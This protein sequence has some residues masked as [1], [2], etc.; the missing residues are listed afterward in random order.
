MP[1]RRQRRGYLD[2]KPTRVDGQLNARTAFY[3]EMLYKIIKSNYEIE[4]P[5]DW[6][7]EIR[8]YMLNKLIHTGYIIVTDS[9]CGV[10]PLWGSLREH[11]FINFPTKYKIALPNL[12]EIDGTLNEDGVLVYQEW[13][14]EGYFYDYN[15]LVDIFATR[16]ASADCA[17]DVNVFNSKLAYIAEAESKAQA[18]TIKKVYD[19]ISE[20]NPI[21]V[22]KNDTIGAEGLKMFF[23]N[24]KNNYIAND[25]LDTKRTIM[26]EFLTC[27]GINNSNTD[28]KERLITSEVDS[29]N[30]ELEVNT[31]LWN[32]NL[33]RQSEK[34]SDVLGIDFDIH[35]KFGDRTEK[36]EEQQMQMQQMMSQQSKGGGKNDVQQQR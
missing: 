34:V 13:C 25:L 32:E 4:C 26:C 31:E 10:L 14:N 17:I 3:R 9:S 1:N 20:G 21:V 5:D 8:E 6:G 36:A 19:A 33:K 12:P 22:T 7:T 18:E 30:E 16:F 23:N 29:N 28:K 35:F 15:R 27:I 2:Q 11:N 24:L